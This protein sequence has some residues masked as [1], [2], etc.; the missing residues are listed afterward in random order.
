MT[1]TERMDHVVIGKSNQPRA[2]RKANTKQMKFLYF[3]NQT[4]WQNRS[5]FAE[6]LRH[7]DAK[8]HGRRVILLLDNASCHFGAAECYNIKLVFLS[9]NMTAY[10]QPLDAGKFE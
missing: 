10:M 8:M 3:N 1:G 4:A 9:P 6:W 5:T 7:F 2:F